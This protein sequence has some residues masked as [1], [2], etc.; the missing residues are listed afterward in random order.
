MQKYVF[1]VFQV[2][3]ISPQFHLKAMNYKFQPPRIRLL[4]SLCLYAMSVLQGKDKVDKVSA[5]TVTH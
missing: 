3:E 4:M 5:L 1:L 2:R